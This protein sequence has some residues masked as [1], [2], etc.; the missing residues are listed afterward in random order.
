MDGLE[1]T[2][3]FIVGVFGIGLAVL[4]FALGFVAGTVFM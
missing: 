2:I 1:S 4:I 3:W